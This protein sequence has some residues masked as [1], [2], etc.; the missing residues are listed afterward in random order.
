VIVIVILIIVSTIFLHYIPIRD[1]YELPKLVGVSVLVGVGAWRLLRKKE[2]VELPL[3]AP[4]S[5]YL[6]FILLSFIQSVNL[7]E[8]YIQFGLDLMGITIFWYIV[9]DIKKI[10]IDRIIDY[11]LASVFI[12]MVISIYY[13]VFTQIDQRDPY[14]IIPPMGNKSFTAAIIMLGIPLGFY[15][16]YRDFDT[17]YKVGFQAINTFV[18]V[19]FLFNA[20]AEA[21]MLGLV[22]SILATSLIIAHRYISKPHLVAIYVVMLSAILTSVSLYY[23]GIL[24]KMEARTSI[25]LNT[26]EMIKDNI[27]GIGRGNFNLLYPKYSRFHDVDYGMAN[28]HFVNNTHNDYLQ[29]YVEVGLFGFLAFMVILYRVVKTDMTARSLALFASAISMLAWAFFY[30]A[31]EQATFVALFWILI[32]LLW[33]T[34]EKDG[35]DS[36]VFEPSSRFIGRGIEAD[37]RSLFE[38][39]GY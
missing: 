2:L 21:A 24:L 17:K 10:D 12:L 6:F 9:N 13:G 38:R 27:F 16:M 19:T 20:A 30:F 14:I 18:M 37:S 1:G 31:F 3:L 23:Q 29:L 4:I 33:V 34:N 15:A 22:I 26:Y 28:F 8:S 36:F 35:S 7:Y 5:L 25:W 32:G 39:G 11:F